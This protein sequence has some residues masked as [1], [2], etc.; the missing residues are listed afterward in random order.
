[1]SREKKISSIDRNGKTSAY[2]R[3]WGVVIRG[4]DMADG[5]ELVL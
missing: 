1:M 4:T 5:H 2:T 3:D